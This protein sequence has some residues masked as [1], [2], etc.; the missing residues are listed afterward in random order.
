MH[1]QLLNYLTPMVGETTAANL[2]KH[3]CARMKLQVEQIDPRHLPVLAD[4]M[5]PMLAVWLGS[6]GAARVAGQIAQLGG[7]EEAR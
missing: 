7:K 3:Y 6:A 4:S 2:L 1:Q 5:R